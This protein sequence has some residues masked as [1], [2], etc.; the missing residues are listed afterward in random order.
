[1]TSLNSGVIPHYLPQRKNVLHLY[2]IL[3]TGVVSVQG[4]SVQGVSVQGVSVQGISVQG[5][6]LSRRVSVQGVSVQGVSVQGVS[7]QGHLCPGESL[8]RGVFVQ[9]DFPHSN[10]W[11]VRI[12]LE[13]ILFHTSFG[14]E[15]N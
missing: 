15:S 7:V 13:C 3:F 9:G 12:L 6:S 1:M 4:I 5:A 10:V 14:P 8:S 11:A 2:I